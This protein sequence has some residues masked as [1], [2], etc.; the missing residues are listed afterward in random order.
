MECKLNGQAKR[1]TQ[2]AGD[3]G[4]IPT[5]L[6]GVGIANVGFENANVETH[7]KAGAQKN[8]AHLFD[9]RPR[10]RKRNHEQDSVLK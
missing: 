6:G 5:A 1:D 4:H 3:A 2:N 10:R 8:T 7:T 9:T